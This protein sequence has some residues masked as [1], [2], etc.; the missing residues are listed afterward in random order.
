MCEIS[1]FTCVVVL[2]IVLWQRWQLASIY[3]ANVAYVSTTRYISERCTML[4]FL[5]LEK[6]EPNG[7][8]ICYLICNAF[9]LHTLYG[10]TCSLSLTVTIKNPHNNTQPP[11]P[12]TFGK[13]NNNGNATNLKAPGSREHVSTLPRC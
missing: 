9:L 6:V 1:L 11:I 10:S 13:E 4:D 8:S 2:L 7:S 5:H 3:V 12:P